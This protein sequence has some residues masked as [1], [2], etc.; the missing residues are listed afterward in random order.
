MPTRGPPVQHE[1]TAP[2]LWWKTR[3][4][5]G[6]RNRNRP[7]DTG[8]AGEFDTSSVA[9]ATPEFSPM[10]IRGLKPPAYPPTVAPRPSETIHSPGNASFAFTTKS[11]GEA[12]AAV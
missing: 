10:I 8:Y 2:V 11:P 7:C 12:F 9:H 6:A 3:H 4:G 1:S 5:N